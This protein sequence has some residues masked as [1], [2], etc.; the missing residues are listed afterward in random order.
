MTTSS[1]SD[2]LDDSSNMETA[3]RRPPARLAK[4]AGEKA[5]HCASASRAMVGWTARNITFRK[6]IFAALLPPPH[7]ATSGNHQE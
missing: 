2:G 6:G 5:A 3:A 4:R 7:P 1:G